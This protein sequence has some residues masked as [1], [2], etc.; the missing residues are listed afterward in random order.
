MRIKSFRI[1]LTCFIL[2]F[3]GGLGFYFFYFN[4]FG[5]NFR[6]YSGYDTF[7]SISQQ[8]A[9]IPSQELGFIPQGIDYIEELDW[10]VV[11]GYR[12]KG[13]ASILAVIERETFDL[14]KSMNLAYADGKPY[15]GHSGGVAVSNHHVWIAS[16]GAVKGI[17]LDDL[18]EARDQEQ[19]KFDREFLTDNNASFAVY[20]D[21]V[22]WVGEFSH[23]SLYPTNPFHTI[24]NRDEQIYSAWVK[25][26]HLNETDNFVNPK[27]L[28]GQPVVPDFIL[29]IPDKVQGLAF[30]DN[31]IFISKSYGR[32]RDSFLVQYTSPLAEK[33]HELVQYNELVVPLWFLDSQNQRRMYKLPPMSEEI[34]AV[35]SQLDILFESGAMQKKGR[36]PLDNVYSLNYM[37]IPPE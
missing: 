13:R 23:G 10:L 6:G 32:Y 27:T 22:L 36:V 31:Q 5:D 8:G 3:A 35:G 25:G 21:E 12:K 14:V 20:A 15:T 18:I 11:S 7:W 34:V 9:F 28:L 19:L 2:I 24:V 26:Y 33:P 16:G 17:H 37:I 30:L 1:A 4:D 29:A